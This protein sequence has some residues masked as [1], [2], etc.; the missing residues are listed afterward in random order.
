M[1][2]FAEPSAGAYTARMSQLGRY[3]IL[4][5]V[6]LAAVGGVML[7]ADRLGLGRLPGDLIWRRK[8]TTVYFPIATSL[9][10][11]IVLTLVLNLLLR[12]K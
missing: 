8:N 5:G 10:V 7:V 1:S 11:S 2:G 3:L 9:L 12:R 4:A 6:V